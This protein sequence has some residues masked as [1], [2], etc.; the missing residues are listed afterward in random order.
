[1]SAWRI[2]LSESVGLNPDAE[3][4][5]LAETEIFHGGIKK[6]SLTLQ[7]EIWW[8]SGCS[9]EG[10]IL[11]TVERQ[12]CGNRREDHQKTSAVACFTRRFLR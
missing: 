8:L 5:A 10:K 11:L 1:M 3:G 7:A 2:I 12:K 6:N 4:E 9:R